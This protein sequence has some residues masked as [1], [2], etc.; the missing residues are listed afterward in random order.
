MLL[1]N[2][3]LTKKTCFKGSKSKVPEPN[4]KMWNDLIEKVNQRDMSP[5]LHEGIEYVV[6]EEF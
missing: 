2:I 6:D 5:F 3:K 1:G 4:L